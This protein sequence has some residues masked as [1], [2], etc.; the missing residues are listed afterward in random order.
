MFREDVTCTLISRYR[1]EMANAST[2]IY[3]KFMKNQE[4]RKKARLLLERNVV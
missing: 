1:L 3:Y 2:D 4:Q